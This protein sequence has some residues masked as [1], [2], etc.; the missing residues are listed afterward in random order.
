MHEGRARRRLTFIKAKLRKG[1]GWQDVQIGNISSSG[2]LVRLADPPPVGQ[3]VEVRHRGC[4]VIGDVV[5]QARSRIG[6]RSHG[7]I[8]VDALVAD[9]GIGKAAS[10]A[11]YE[12]PSPSVWKRLRGRLN[13]D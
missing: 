4:R 11:L 3:T 13:A 8:D 10:E 6:V 5:W 9:S 7:P 1:D 2:L 12:M